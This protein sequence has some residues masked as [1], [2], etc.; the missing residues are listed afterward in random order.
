MDYFELN[1]NDFDTNRLERLINL[2]LR[3]NFNYLEGITID[4]NVGEDHQF[5][6]HLVR[7]IEV[8]SRYIFEERLQDYL[9]ES[10][11]NQGTGLL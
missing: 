8:A 2:Y 6:V 5:G 4:E 11:R 10:I 3:E 7:P 1:F 9:L